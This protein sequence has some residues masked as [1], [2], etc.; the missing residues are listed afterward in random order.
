MSGFQRTPPGR[1][2]FQRTPLPGRRVRRRMHVEP[3]D[4]RL[5][6]VPMAAAIGVVATILVG[7]LWALTVALDAWLGH[8]DA[9]VRWI[10]L[11]QGAS[12]AVAVGIWIATPKGRR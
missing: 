11:F 7:Q 4:E 8:D 6:G 1:S 9:A 3:N 2:G 10:L 5:Y 12:F